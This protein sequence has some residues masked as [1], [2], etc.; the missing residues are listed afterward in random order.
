MVIFGGAAVWMHNM[1][2]QVYNEELSR[3]FGDE[4]SAAA[5][6]QPYANANAKWGSAGLAGLIFSFQV[7]KVIKWNKLHKADMAKFVSDW[8]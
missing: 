3:P 4:D 8:R 5:A 6:A 7:T 1:E 2:I